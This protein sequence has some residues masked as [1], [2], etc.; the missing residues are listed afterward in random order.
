M[1]SLVEAVIDAFIDISSHKLRTF[2]Q[3]LGVVLGVGSL[4]AVQGLT[5]SG[6]RQSMRLMSESGGLTKLLVVN[7]PPKETVLSARTKAST[8]L[9]LE[10]AA[11][12]RAEVEHVEQVDPIARARLRV[13]QGKYLRRHEIA[14]VTPDYTSVYRFYIDRGRFIS[15]DDVAT[16]AR[17][18]VLGTTAARRYFGNENPVGRTLHIDGIGFTVVGVMQHKEFFFGEGDNNALEWMNRQT[19]V[20][21]TA[22]YTRFTGD[23]NH[24]VGYINVVTDDAENNPKVV[25]AIDTL[26]YRRH[27]G[28]DDFEVFNRVERMRRQQQQ[29]QI[30]DITFLVTGIVSLIVGGIVI[31]NIMLA[32][33]QERVREIGIRKAVGAGGLHIGVQF[34]VESILVTSL[35]GA[36]GLLVGMGF[37]QIITSLIGRPAEIT[38]NMAMVSLLSSVAIGVGFGLYPAI[39]AARLH[40]VQALRYE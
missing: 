15:E 6:R 29:G 38:M 33:F 27:G 7:R 21:I 1:M 28:V 2:L 9:T 40:P 8:G 16:A 39:R 22:I 34:L 13:S 32:S 19:F 23:T 3:T 18:T 5:D 25:E 14:G 35:G 12:I 24:P 31:M 20:P 11:A 37:A 36:V 4:V 30:F 26:L 17:I 10:D